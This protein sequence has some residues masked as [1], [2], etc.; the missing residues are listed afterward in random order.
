MAKAV[1]AAGK[2][3]DRPFDR[4]VALLGGERMFAVPIESPLDAH[5]V[6]MNGF[7]G[8]ALNFLADEIVVLDLEEMLE[9]AIGISP[10][11]YQ[12]RKK[13]G[14]GKPLSSEQ[15]GRMWKYAEIMARAMAL[16]GTQED[17]EIW[18]NSP[19]MGLNQQRPIDLL[20]TPAGVELVEGLLGRMEYGVYT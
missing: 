16:F 10:R 2:G 19:A 8:K 14:S 11:T 6:I 1:L 9:K 18:L 17:A 4:A 12:R 13:Q 5:Q 3:A 15:S 7:P 20:G